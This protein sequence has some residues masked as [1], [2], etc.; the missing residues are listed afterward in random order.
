M[1]YY[2]IGYTFLEII[3]A[4]ALIKG[5]EN[6]LNTIK[7][8]KENLIVIT[9]VMIFVLLALLYFH[10]QNTLWLIKYVNK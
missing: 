5:G 7:E 10:V 2:I 3:I 9:I 6:L 4:W 1:I 8:K